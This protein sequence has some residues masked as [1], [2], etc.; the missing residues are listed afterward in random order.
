MHEAQTLDRTVAGAQAMMDR[1]PMLFHAVAAHGGEW[2]PDLRDTTSY[3]MDANRKLP[4][5]EIRTL[6]HQMA[7]RTPDGLFRRNQEW[8]SGPYAPTGWSATATAP[9]MWPEIVLADLPGRRLA[10]V[11]DLAGAD[12]WVIE[13][14]VR[15][16]GFQVDLVLRRA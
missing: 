14:A 7:W 1:D 16:P 10:D 2:R 5:I 9:D 6:R 11:V 8:C 15:V 4:E 3:A 12:A 13:A